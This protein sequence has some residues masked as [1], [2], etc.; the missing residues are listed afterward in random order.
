MENGVGV[1]RRSLYSAH[2]FVRIAR[3][4]QASILPQ[5]FEQLGKSAFDGPNATV[6]VYDIVSSARN[7]RRC[8]G[9]CDFGV[10]HRA[11]GTAKCGKFNMVL[12][13]ELQLGGAILGQTPTK[14]S[15]ESHTNEGKQMNDINRSRNDATNMVSKTN[16]GKSLALWGVLLLVAPLV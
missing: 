5:P 14:Q 2:G 1:V 11:F 16:T 6:T 10:S 8:G 3:S 15:S 7:D 9:S 12:R 4:I 13:S